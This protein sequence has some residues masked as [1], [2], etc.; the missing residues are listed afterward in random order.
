MR[1]GEGAARTVL[2]LCL[3]ISYGASADA[4]T[5]HRFSSGWEALRPHRLVGPR[6]G[7]FAVPGWA[8]GQTRHWL[9]NVSI[10]PDR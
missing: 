9:D 10:D 1:R 7:R 4:T 6:A 3:L 2:I 8:A 5:T